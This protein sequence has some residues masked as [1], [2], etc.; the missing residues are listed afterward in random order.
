MYEE[1]LKSLGLTDNEVRIYL[2][3]LQHGSL[4][5]AEISQK[6]GLHRGYV[7]D[8]LD[9]MQEKEVVSTVVLNDKKS[10]QA[11]SPETLVEL[12]ALKLEEFQKTVPELMKLESFSKEDTTV[13]L[14]KGRRSYRTLIKDVI[15]STRP[16]QEILL[17][18]IDEET[19]VTEI[20]PIYLKQYVNAL[21][22]R[23]I[24]ERII[25]KTGAKTLVS[26]NLQYRELA[27]E[28]IG[29]TAQIIYGNKVALFLRGNPHHLIIIENKDIAETYRKQFEL[30]WKTAKKK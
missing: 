4:S 1:Q 18:G 27:E 5:P 13:G 29:K 2:L 10:F 11:T 21:A 3:L 8:A 25:I 23:G 19:L 9:R 17:F 20:E 16:K 28:F 30:L 6:L 24:H 7:Y 14:N 12:L 22:K 15:A 26:K